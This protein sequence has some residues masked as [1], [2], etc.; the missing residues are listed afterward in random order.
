MGRASS[1][2][3]AEAGWR[4]ACVDIDEERVSETARQIHS[5]GGESIAVAADLSGSEGNRRMVDDTVQAFGGLD[6]LH[7]NA[8]IR[9]EPVCESPTLADWDRIHRLTLRGAFLGIRHVIPELRKRGGGAIIMTT[10]PISVAGDPH[11]AAMS[12]G[13]RSLCR[14][15]ATGYGRDN[16][17]VNAICPG[18]VETSLLRETLAGERSDLEAALTEIANRLPLR[19]LALPRDVAK[20]AVFLAS[21]EASYVTGTD[22]VVDG[23]LLAVVS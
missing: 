3:F 9:T 21:P 16:I 14:S 11:L 5:S 20:V 6:A 10:A 18:T 15:V 7:T 4:V 1:L 19:R 23:G 2:Q 12:G 13:L 22:V 8:A 17:R